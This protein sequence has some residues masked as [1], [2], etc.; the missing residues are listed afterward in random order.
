MTRTTIPYEE[1][2]ERL[3]QDPATRQA[4]DDL[5]P[6]YQVACLR[7]QHGLTQQQLADLVGTKQPSIARLESGK[8]TP[9]LSFLQRVAEALGGHLVVKIELQAEQK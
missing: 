2:K 3:L 4:Y 6:A 7:I 1:V 9:S 8:G 5:E